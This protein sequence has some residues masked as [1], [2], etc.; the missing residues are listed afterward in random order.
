MKVEIQEIE[1]LARNVSA[2]SASIHS[3]EAHYDE[4]YKEF[5][6]N[7]SGFSGIWN[8]CVEWG[9]I[10]TKAYENLRS[11]LGY[12]WGKEVDWIQSIINFSSYILKGNIE[13]SFQS[14]TDSILL[15]KL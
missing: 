12:E 9:K 7:F 5:S 2:L 14:A 6:M 13:P 3:D 4:F 10:F 15:T 1:E 8:A 11:E